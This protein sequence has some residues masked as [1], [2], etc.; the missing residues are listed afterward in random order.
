DRDNIAGVEVEGLQAGAHIPAAHGV[1]VAPA[2]EPPVGGEGQ[3]G[4]HA[5]VPRQDVGQPAGYRVPHAHRP[6]DAAAGDV[7]AVRAPGH[8]PDLL[9]VSGQDVQRLAGRRVPDAQVFTVAADQTLPIGAVRDAACV[10][11]LSGE[12]EDLL[13]G[14]WVPHPDRLV[15]ARGG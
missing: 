7:P 5:G 14:G 11:A 6:V 15:P 3:A 12:V 4:H 2:E 9:G 13:P 10:R 8:A 1:V